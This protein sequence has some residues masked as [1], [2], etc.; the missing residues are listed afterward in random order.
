MGHLPVPPH[1]AKPDEPPPRRA[2]LA[3]VPD[4][5]RSGVRIAK[6]TAVAQAKKIDYSVDH[7]WRRVPAR[8][9]PHEA[10][11]LAS[12]DEALAPIFT[13][14]RAL[15]EVHRLDLALFVVF[16]E[17]ALRVSGALVR[18]APSQD[19]LSFSAQQT[20]D[21]AH[22]YEMF[23]RRSDQ[24]RAL[25]GLPPGQVDDAILTPPLRRFIDRC[26]EVAD[27]GS[28]LEGMT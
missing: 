1:P 19:A 24:S 15:A 23:L 18:R 27:S 22:H 21:E 10:E 26:Y 14:S 11:Q 13:E 17:A 7:W 12:V 20:L 6:E 8:Q 5:R 25:C 16:E 2:F 3:R 4:R 9:W 28:F